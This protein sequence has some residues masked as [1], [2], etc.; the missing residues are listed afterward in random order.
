MPRDSA[1]TKARL[2][3]AAFAEFAAYG[4]AGARVD[5]IAE[6]A[7]ANKQRIYAYFG[8]KEQL[9]DAVIDRVLAVGAETVPFD[10]EDLPGVAGQIFDNLIAHP[11]LMRLLSWKLL[12]RPGATD[13][14]AATYTAKTTAVAAAQEQGRVEPE[15]GPED[16]VAF[17]LALTQAWF[18]LTGGMSP[19]SGSD[20]WSTRRLARH[21]D[22]VVDAVR[23]ITTPHR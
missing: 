9:F 10:A 6:A 8:N 4:L 13:Q 7:N 5:R 15:L 21:R 16:L 23:Q 11:D 17:V 18:S 2:L 14:E 22:A 3:D 1:A 20:P 19:T 12:E